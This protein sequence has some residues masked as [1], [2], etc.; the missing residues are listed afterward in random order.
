MPPLKADPP[1][2][3]SPFQ[4]APHDLGSTHFTTGW[5]VPLVVERLD[6]LRQGKGPAILEKVWREH[7]GEQL[8]FCAWDWRTLPEL[9]GLLVRGAVGPSAVC[10][11]AYADTCMYVT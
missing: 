6:L 11:V 7:H 8:K 10:V 4:D 1:A 3:L 5:R 2:C 9:Q